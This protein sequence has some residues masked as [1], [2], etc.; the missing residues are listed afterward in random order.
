MAGQNFICMGLIFLLWEIRNISKRKSRNPTPIRQ[1]YTYS[2]LSAA[3][4]FLTLGIFH[5]TIVHPYFPQWSESAGIGLI[6]SLLLLIRLNV[7][8]KSGNRLFSSPSAIPQSLLFLALIIY[9]LCFILQLNP[10][11]T[12]QFNDRVLSTFLLGILLC[13]NLGILKNAVHEHGIVFGVLFL[14]WNRIHYYRLDQLKNMKLTLINHS[15]LLPFAEIEFHPNHRGIVENL[16]QRN[17]SQAMR[18][19]SEFDP[20]ADASS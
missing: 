10:E 2:S 12:I 19:E 13:L 11:Y 5:I 3:L 4:F 15:L 8:M 6:L 17:A 7:K 16:L 20:L 1:R 14:P 18:M 9:F